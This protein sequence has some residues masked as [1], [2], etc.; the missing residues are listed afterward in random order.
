MS[1]EILELY[2]EAVS[3]LLFLV[4]D[5]ATTIDVEYFLCDFTMRS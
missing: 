5:L 3:E 4:A 1:Y 2:V